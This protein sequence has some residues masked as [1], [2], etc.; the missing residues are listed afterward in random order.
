MDGSFKAFKKGDKTC[1][2]QDLARKFKEDAILRLALITNN[3]HP[4]YKNGHPKHK[5]KTGK[6]K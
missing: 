5:E 4:D 6:S 3:A 2:V 1:V